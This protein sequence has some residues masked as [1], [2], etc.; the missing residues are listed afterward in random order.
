[1]SKKIILESKKDRSMRSIIKKYPNLINMVS[2]IFEF[3]TPDSKYAQ[4]IEKNLNNDIEFY[5]GDYL[6]SSQ[7]DL[8]T[9]WYRNLPYF[10]RNYNRLTPELVSKIHDNYPLSDIDKAIENPKDI[11]SYTS[12]DL[13]RIRNFLEKNKS[14]SELEKEIKK[15]AKK[16]YEDENILVVQPMTLKSSCYYGAETRW[17]TTSTS[18]DEFDRHFK[19]GNLYYFI[20]KGEPDGKWALF[21][22]NDGSETEVFDSKNNKSSVKTLEKEFPELMEVIGK[23]SKN[24]QDYINLSMY[25]ITGNQYLLDRNT[26][27]LSQLG[28]WY[29]VVEVKL[30]L[31]EIMKVFGIEDDYEQRSIQ[32]V[33]HSY[34]S[35]EHTDGWYDF[36]D[37]YVF[38]HFNE[39]NMELLKKIASYIKPEILIPDINE[40]ISTKEMNE[41]IDKLNDLYERDVDYIISEYTTLNDQSFE[42]GAREQI[43]SSIIKEM[44]NLGFEYVEDNNRRSDVWKFS[45]M[46][47]TLATL[48]L[49]SDAENLSVIELLS[50]KLD[51]ELDFSE[52]YIYEYQ[53][54]F[55]SDGFNN[56]IESHLENILEKIEEDNSPEALEFIE[57][58]RKNNY[59]VK[60]TYKIPR[61][62]KYS[63]RIL[64]IDPEDGTVTFDMIRDSDNERKR[65]APTFRGFIDFIYNPTL[66]DEFE[67]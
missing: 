16:I 20:K 53:G 29:P 19:N 25:L 27:N 14:K 28:M 30:D 6:S 3:D 11:F 1:M 42:E 66:F 39:S 43:N 33:Y 48:F 35:Y 59:K 7:I 62:D 61:S 34:S 55:D 21:V 45:I 65:M 10:E 54:D 57:F 13:F 24:S 58:L 9:E 49:T 60:G 2:K 50:K 37:G 63:F 5:G 52:D 56:Y 64:E 40:W 36:R 17:C 47:T 15:D 26:N 31:D 8:I 51:G 67:E 4:W 32:Q 23:L 12:N 22:S 41:F 44:E 38:R 46:G 18:S